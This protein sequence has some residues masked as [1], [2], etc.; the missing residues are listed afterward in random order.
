MGEEAKED[1]RR[2]S[3]IMIFGIILGAAAV[4]ALVLFLFYNSRTRRAVQSER[5]NYTSEIAGQLT[6]NIDNLQNSYAREV[7]E[8][9]NTVREFKPASLEELRQLYTDRENARHFIISESGQIKDLSGRRYTLSD[10]L[11]ADKIYRAGSDEVVMSYTTVNFESDYLIF[12]KQMEEP[13]TIEGTTYVAWAV[14]VTSDQF[15]KNMTVSLFKGLGA[16]YLIARDG[17]VVIKPNESSMVFAG[18]NL[19]SA[20]SSGGVTEEQIKKIRSDMENGSGS[21]SVTVNGLNWLIASKSTEFDGN[22]IVV[23]VPLSLTAA[24]TFTSMNLTVTFAAIF[25]IALAGIMVLILVSAFNR[26]REEDKRAAATDAQTSFL[27]KMSHDIRTPLNAVIGMLQLAADP[28]HSRREIDGF[29]EKAQESADYLLE[30]INGMLD[31]QKIGSG[32][33]KIADE[34]FSMQK[35]LNGIESMY[36][37]VLE[38]KGLTFIVEDSGPFDC[39]YIGD[40]VKIK[41]ILMNLLSNAMKFTREGGSVKLSASRTERRENRDT[42]LLTVA[43]TG[44]G[45]SREFQQRIFHPFEQERQSFTSGYTGTG[46]GLNIVKNLT[47]LMGG[48]VQVKSEPGEGSCFEIR[49]P[50]QRGDPAASPE[51]EKT[52][53]GFTPFH[54]Q[55]ILLAEDNMINQQIA[56]ML[57]KERLQLNADAVDNGQQ[58]VEAMER[59]SPGEYAAVILDVRMPVMDGLQAARTIR[60]LPHPDAK[61]IPIL[62]LS[63]NTYDEDIRQSLK[64]GMNAHL[65]KPI[66]IEELSAVLHEYIH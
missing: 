52:E 31:L 12:G 39:G 1:G 64:A 58:A 22:Y 7:R 18:Y 61:T 60:A 21:V 50:L 47:E 49:L 13:Q 43:D 10:E 2:H 14:G 38:K 46:L 65:A 37:P 28:K 62:A 29:I 44:I 55:K 19:F 26:R 45:M 6:R 17:T 41:Q 35:L 4:C 53:S 24:E 51:E 33:M 25:I 34:P 66:N 59:S 32:K 9:E 42:V 30:L 11:F 20:L 36:R 23:A 54:G 5:E 27:T 3:P 16:G 15:R 48:T 63:A 56:V 8:D 40:G 57:M